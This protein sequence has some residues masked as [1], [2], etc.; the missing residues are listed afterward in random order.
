MRKAYGR[1]SKEKGGGP[2]AKRSAVSTS[3]GHFP[4]AL[5]FS[6]FPYEQKHFKTS[7][8]GLSKITHRN[9]IQT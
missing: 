4:F 7:H 1:E 6:S 2:A 5:P 3:R 9:A 8:C